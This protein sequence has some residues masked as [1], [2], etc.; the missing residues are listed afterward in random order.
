VSGWAVV[1]FGLI[2]FSLATIVLEFYRGMRARQLMVGEGAGEAL[3][4]LISK[5]RRRYGG[6][7]V[8]L[9]VL[10][11][12]VAI[13]TTSVFRAER[14]VTLAQ[15]NEFTMAGYTVR[16]EGLEDRDTPHV[17]HVM[18]RMGVFE[19][20]RRIVTLKPEKRFYKKPEQPSTE[21]AIWSR[22]ATDLYLVLGGVDEDTRRVTILAYLN[23][24]INLLWWGGLVMALGTGVA[25]WPSRAAVRASAY[26]PESGSEH[27]AR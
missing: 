18:A 17:L 22:M 2:A 25:A 15:G 24:L 9:G 11:I 5:N 16:Y 19:D 1:S 23:P 21:V 4:R 20:G 14:Q 26:A 12:F 8:H 27:I 13:T 10:M 6:Y 7:I 3:A